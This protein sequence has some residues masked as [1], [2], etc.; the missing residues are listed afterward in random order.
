MTA[1]ELYQAIVADY[2]DHLPGTRPVHAVGIVATGTFVPSPVAA[3]FTSAEHFRGDPVA[4]TVR[5]ANGSGSSTVHDG[6]RDV[7]GLSTKFHLPSGADTDLLMVTMPL[8]F[9]ATPAEFLG[10]VRAGVPAPRPAAGRLGRTADALRLRIPLPDPEPDQPDGLEGVVE[11]ADANPSAR[12]GT[13]AMMSL[14]TPT[15]YARVAY[16]A[17][18][19]FALT[20]DAG[21]VRYARFNWDP[22]AGVR[23]YPPPA[24]DDYLRAELAARLAQGPARFVLRMTLAEPGDP[25]DDPTRWWDTT[26]QR[27]VMGELAVTALVDDQDEANERLSFNPAR[28]VPG[29]GCPPDPVFAARGPAYEYS[30]RQRGGSGCPVLGAS[31]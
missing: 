6:S 2:P 19:A 29:F 24:P 16:H 26:R 20:D 1:E 17:L 4:V 25:L 23:P 8:F 18:H 7:R 15:S 11:F 22:V 5:F 21:A 10:F 3:R 30:C 12:A 28:L 31:G 27:V 13:V 14:V 9:A